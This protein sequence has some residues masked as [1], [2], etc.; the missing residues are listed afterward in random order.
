MFIY[1]SQGKKDRKDYIVGEYCI[2]VSEESE[3]SEGY[4]G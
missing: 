3:L 4:Y 1:D 2:F